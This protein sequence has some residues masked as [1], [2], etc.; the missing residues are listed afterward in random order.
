MDQAREEFEKNYADAVKRVNHTLLEYGWAVAPHFITG[1]D[2]KKLD[3]Y[4]RLLAANPPADRQMAHDRIRLY[5]APYAFLPFIR[6]CNLYRA[7]Q[8]PYMNN[9]A[10]VI[11]RGTLHY[12]KQDFLSA[13]YTMIPGVEGMLREHT[14][15][16]PNDVIG[17]KAITEKLRA[18]SSSAGDGFLKRRHPLYRDALAQTLD[19]WIYLPTKKADFDL[20]HLNRHYA[21]HGLGQGKFYSRADCERLF[22]LFDLYAETII[23]ETGTG[24]ANFRPAPENTPFVA[25]RMQHYISLL[26]ANPPLNTV[27]TVEERFMREYPGYVPVENF[28]TLT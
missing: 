13:V 21:M 7:I 2:F 15:I 17:Y 11:E 12:Y 24:Y 4:C 5:L 19:R 16:P 3:D 14:Q 25:L 18:R 9:F 6:A 23:C 20:S 8:L 27:I 28:A 1:G 26:T 10:H 22:L